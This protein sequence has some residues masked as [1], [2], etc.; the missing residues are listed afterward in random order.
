MPSYR[1]QYILDNE[2]SDKPLV[3][4]T[5]LVLATSVQ[6]VERVATN[7]LSRYREAVGFR[8]IDNA[9]CVVAS[10]FTQ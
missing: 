7:E 6:A 2:T 9:D 10:H 4:R 3:A 8:I 5:D 1:I